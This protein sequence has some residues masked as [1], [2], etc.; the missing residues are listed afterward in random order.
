MRVWPVPLP[1]PG[2]GLGKSAAECPHG[3]GRTRATHAHSVLLVQG[4]V[5]TEYRGIVLLVA[6]AE[7]ESVG[8]RTAH[9]IN[10]CG[11]DS[12]RN[13][14]ELPGTASAP[15]RPAPNQNWEC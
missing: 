6:V 14:Q 13:C 8:H 9:R 10:G 1:D 2:N 4:S 11:S 3:K 15:P 7:Q 5:R 12:G